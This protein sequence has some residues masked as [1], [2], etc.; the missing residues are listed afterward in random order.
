M[1]EKSGVVTEKNS[2]QPGEARRPFEK[3]KAE[4]LPVGELTILSR[5]RGTWLAVGHD[6]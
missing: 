4:V 6:M 5:D 3:G 1:V 2:D